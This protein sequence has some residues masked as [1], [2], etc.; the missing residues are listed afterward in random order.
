MNEVEQAKHTPDCEWTDL[1]HDGPM[2]RI[3]PHGRVLSLTNWRG[4]GYRELTPVLNEDGYPSVRRSMDGGSR[5]HVAIHVLMAPIYCGPR[6]SPQHEVRH[7]DGD[8]TNCLAVN[9]AWG[10]RKENADD[11]E[12][13]GRTSRGDA[14]SVAIRTSNHSER[15]ARG[16]T[17]YMRRQMAE[18]TCG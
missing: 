8:K 6:P 7:L 1:V 2:Y 18:V 4:Y 13:H 17:H 16:D 9:L 11:R 10:T 5:K 15:V 14:H 12:K 3:C